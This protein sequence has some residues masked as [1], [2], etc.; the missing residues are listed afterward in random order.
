MKLII[1][2]AVALIGC[3]PPPQTYNPTPEQPSANTE[4]PM[5]PEDHAEAI[6][7]QVAIDEQAAREREIEAARHGDPALNW[8]NIGIST[9]KFS[10]SMSTSVHRTYEEC[11]AHGGE[12]DHECIPISALPSSY[13]NAH[14]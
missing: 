2:L 7:A 4:T 11:A 13:W 1:A 12:E 8:V 10:E 5:T 6:A 14:P 3:G 9:G